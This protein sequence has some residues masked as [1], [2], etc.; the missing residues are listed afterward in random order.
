MRVSP[1]S[2]HLRAA[3][4]SAIT[5]IL[6]A[7][8][9]SSNYSSTASADGGSEGGT[10]SPTSSDAGDSPARACG[11]GKKLCSG[12]CVALDDPR[13]GCA[14][15]SCE[16][17][18]LTN[19]KSHSCDAAGKCAVEQ[20]A[21]GWDFCD[22]TKGCTVDPFSP[23]TCNGC[24]AR[25]GKACALSEVCLNRACVDAASA[26]DCGAPGSGKTFTN[27]ARS[28]VNLATH[29]RHCG[30]CATECQPTPG[31]SAACSGSKCVIDC[32]ENH[33]HCKGDA[34]TCESLLPV[35]AD[36]DGDTWGSAPV[37]VEGGI[38]QKFSC[39]AG[40]GE[41]LRGGDCLDDPGVSASKDVFPG[42][43]RFFTQSFTLAGQPSFDYN[44]NGKTDVNQPTGGSCSPC[45]TGFIGKI[46]CGVASSF[47]NCGAAPVEQQPA[48][49]VQI[50]K[51]PS[52]S[53]GTQVQCPLSAIPSCR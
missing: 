51:L 12:E 30:A 5:V 23:D 39:T 28:C 37:I 29:P 25:G 15:E 24:G 1:A 49:A 46:T 14:A 45:V 53:S 38:L 31:G 8:A 11:D 7:V 33:G 16:P 20:C 9:C 41:A 36:K 10:I 21:P 2:P 52:S 44:C 34:S 19:T 13:Y 43:T 35:Y 17:C 27:C 26:T 42:Q 4:L 32:D 6:T 48:E 47:A 22:A 50:A 40:T 18:G 3:T